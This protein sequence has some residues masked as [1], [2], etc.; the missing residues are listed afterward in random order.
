MDRA[1]NADVGVVG[2]HQDGVGVH[3]LVQCLLVAFLVFFYEVF[4]ASHWLV[5]KTLVLI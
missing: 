1:Q 5:A 4:D 2:E 3:L